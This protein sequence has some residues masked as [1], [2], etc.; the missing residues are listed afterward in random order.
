M[1]FKK[2]IITI[3]LLI[4]C[5]L[6]S[7]GCQQLYTVG[8]KPSDNAPLYFYIAVDNSVS[9][10]LPKV[11]RRVNRNVQ[12]VF[13][14]AKN[15]LYRQLIDQRVFQEGDRLVGISPF[16]DEAVG[17]IANT[18]TG[19]PVE[20]RSDT[21]R[22][23]TT[24]LLDNL[25]KIKLRELRE[26]DYKTYY[27]NVL[28]QARTEFLK[29][30]STPDQQLC[31]LLTD[32]RGSEF[33]GAPEFPPEKYPSYYVIKLEAEAVGG[34]KLAVI[35]NEKLGEFADQKDAP[36]ADYVAAIRDRYKTLNTIP[37]QQMSWLRLGVVVL[38]LGI[39]AFMWTL[40]VKSQGRDW[41]WRQQAPQLN[42][43]YN[44]NISR[45]FLRPER[46]QLPGDRDRYWLDKG[47]ELK[48]PSPQG[49]W[50]EPVES[51]QP[52][53]YAITVTPDNGQPVTGNFTV[54]EASKAPPEI[55]ASYDATKRMLFLIPHNC[56]LPTD[57]DRY[58]FGETVEIE[59][60]DADAGKLVL[61]RPLQAG[62]HTIKVLL[63]DGRRPRATFEAE[64]PPP[65]TPRY[66]VS[67][68]R[69]SDIGNPTTVELTGHEINLLEKEGVKASIW[70]KRDD[71]Y[72]YLRSTGNVQRDDGTPVIGI[73]QMD[74]GT[75]IT[76]PII[77]ALEDERED[78]EI[79]V[80]QL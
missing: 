66:A 15:A 62:R 55:T 75:L 28:D 24:L 40:L 39:L 78:V 23:L 32:E 6:G 9:Y 56:H 63:D 13:D 74:L 33:E 8:Q 1:F 73:L 20:V 21:L 58:N 7:T 3:A 64:P 51:L 14:D 41:L 76:T 54:G 17:A 47:G 68:A 30:K 22:S 12:R 52:G 53:R 2:N 43:E 50:I 35:P 79:T 67:I 45:I 42:A 61:A 29:L 5:L 26:R 71:L 11:G 38:I 60:L 27:R 48:N 4:F 18:L 16:T 57:G 65:P 25:E 46:F 59:S 72:L 31:I 19:G 70:V 36:V 34:G 69:Y 44:P 49:G 10:G 37:V 80:Q 77:L